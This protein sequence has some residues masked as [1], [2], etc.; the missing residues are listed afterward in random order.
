MIVGTIDP[1]SWVNC[2]KS[3]KGQDS[4][5]DRKIGYTI[6]HLIDT[7]KLRYMHLTGIKSAT[8][9]AHAGLYITKHFG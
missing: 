2:Y 7:T 8:D 1:I 9:M 5:N 3:F 6:F 4:P